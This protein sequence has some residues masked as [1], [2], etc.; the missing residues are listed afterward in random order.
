MKKSLCITTITLKETVFQSAQVDLIIGFPN[1]QMVVA[2]RTTDLFQM[3]HKEV[4][5]EVN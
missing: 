5:E 2:S 3:A 1:H 4:Q